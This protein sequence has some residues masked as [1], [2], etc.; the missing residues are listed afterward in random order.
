MSIVLIGMLM[1]VCATVLVTELHEF[2]GGIFPHDWIARSTE[3]LGLLFFGICLKHTSLTVKD[4]GII[5]NNL[6][7]ELFESLLVVAVMVGGMSVAKGILMA[8]GST[9]FAAN[10]PFFDFTAPSYLYI[11]YMGI[12]FIQELQTKCGLQKS[13]SKILDVKYVNT[14]LQ[15][16]AISAWRKVQ[17]L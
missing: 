15:L 9:L 7:K 6:K 16:Y 12:V 14:S 1:I 4:F 3:I 11:K 17:K 13:I 2:L 10:R 5:P 8:N